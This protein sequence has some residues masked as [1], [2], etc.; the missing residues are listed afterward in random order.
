[1]AY[2]RMHAIKATVGKSVEYICNPDKTDNYRLVSTFSCARKTAE[3]DFRSALSK[4]GQKDRNM[5]YHI[6]QSFS[7]G[8]V[9]EEEAHRIG[10]ELADRFLKGDYSYVIATH[11]DKNHCH[12]HLIFC[13]ADN[14][15]HKKYNECTKNYYLLRKISDELCK[16]HNLSV[17]P[18]SKNK[19]KTYTEW[20]AIRDGNSWKEKMRQDID[21][22]IKEADSYEK[23]LKVIR[24]KGYE[25]KGEKLEGNTLK[26]ISFRA[27]GYKRFVRG[28]VRSLGAKYTREEIFR[29]IKER[30]II[31]VPE[32]KT[33]RSHNQ[34]ILKRTAPKKKLIDTSTDRFQ[35]SPGLKHWADIQNLK[36]AASAYAEAKNLT[37]LKEKIEKKAAEASD[38]RNE[39]ISIGKELKE[40]KEI[41]YYLIQYRDNAPFKQE[42]KNSK[43]PEAYYMDHEEQIT[44]FDGA[45]NKL[46]EYGIKPNV[47]ELKQIEED[48]ET[49]EKK[50]AALE[51]KYNAVK[52]DTADLEQKYQ[53]I[54]E[55]LGIDPSTNWDRKDRK[56]EN[57]PEKKKK[58]R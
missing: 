56:P 17:I 44:L 29:R 14:T 36:T 3:F 10:M 53:T 33:V 21:I 7:P 28:S 22:A 41:Q 40:L 26:Y 47:S 39:L 24:E 20:K 12:N 48:I 46:R 9:S 54:T 15:R 57:K 43:D 18:P 25:V 13:A 58:Q 16:E 5:A 45:K 51:K 50:E 52:K 19:G 55:Y 4:T 35:K 37:E 11:T 23:F 32:P 27:K 31:P 42:Y 8:E 6:I 34:D 30:E 1:M 2:T 49:L 38:I